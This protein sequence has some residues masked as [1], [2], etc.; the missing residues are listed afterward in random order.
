MS[1][2]RKLL[3]TFILIFIGIGLLGIYYVIWL[4]NAPKPVKTPTKAQEVTLRFIEGWNTTQVASY[5]NY[6]GDRPQLAHIVNSA[7]FLTAQKQYSIKDYP[8]LT[9]KPEKSDL[10]GFLF[11][12]SYRFYQSALTLASSTPVEISNT[13]IKK[14]LD[15]FVLKFTPEMQKQAE[16]QNLS[17]YKIITLA[18]VLEKETGSSMAE[19]KTVAGI[20]Y[21]RLRIGMPL[22]SDATVNYATKKDLPSPTEADTKIDSPYNTYKYPGLPAGPICNPSLNSIIAAL[23][24]EDTD[25]LYFLHDQKTGQAYYAKTYEQ[26]L[27]NKYKYLK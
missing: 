6:D 8:L 19:K 7:D 10:E 5:L 21:N 15:N 20:F 25:Y 1:I 27:A 11:P 3:T 9:S 12:D 2:I 23:E 13:I 17:V 14:M 18:S 24:P 22:Q 16:K 4:K 26:H